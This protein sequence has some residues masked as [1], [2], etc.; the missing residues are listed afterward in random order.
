VKLYHATR[1]DNLASI[2][3]HGLLVQKADWTAKLKGCWMVSPRE[4]GR[5]LAWATLHTIRKHQAQLEDGIL[6]EVNI[7][8]SKLTHFRDGLYYS[9]QDVEPS[10]LGQVIEGATFGASVSE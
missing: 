6:I 5:F 9:T 10:R 1:R 2:I 7:P 4:K 3:E 8:R